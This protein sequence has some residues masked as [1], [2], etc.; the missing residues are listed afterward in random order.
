[1]TSMGHPFYPATPV[2]GAAAAYQWLSRWFW[3]AKKIPEGTCSMEQITIRINYA[4]CYGMLIYI[5]CIWCGSCLLLPAC[6]QR[7]VLV[8]LITHLAIYRYQQS[9]VRYWHMEMMWWKARPVAS[10]TWEFDLGNFLACIVL[11]W[12][13]E[14]PNILFYC[15]DAPACFVTVPAAVH[16]GRLNIQ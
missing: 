2:G 13:F 9:E 16:Q 4:V 5:Y 12:H 11:N 15:F 14:F 3:V 8:G 1:M 10:W 6:R 7:K